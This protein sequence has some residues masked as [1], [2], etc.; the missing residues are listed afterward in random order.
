MRR[1][2]GQSWAFWPRRGVC[3][4]LCRGTDIELYQ[5][6][7]TRL[8]RR[9]S[10]WMASGAL[11][12]KQWKR[13]LN[14]DKSLKGSQVTNGKENKKRMSLYQEYGLLLSHRPIK[15]YK[16][17][18]EPLICNCSN[19]FLSL[20]IVLVCTFKCVFEQLNVTKA[21]YNK[22]WIFFP[23]CF[24]CYFQHQRKILLTVSALSSYN[25]FVFPNNV[26]TIS[27]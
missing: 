17:Y 19:P 22:N 11:R 26:Y 27:S 7:R 14:N 2:K 3:M 20:V 4:R 5:R 23:D 13:E 6:Q 24:S 8:S 10:W 15:Q 16:R 1:E 21:Y 18:H 25:S 9:S 12:A